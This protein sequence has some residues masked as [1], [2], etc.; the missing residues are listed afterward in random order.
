MKRFI[1]KSVAILLLALFFLNSVVP[2]GFAQTQTAN[3]I[4]V[5]TS[6]LQLTSLSQVYHP[7]IVRGLSIYPNDPF[8]FDFIVDT[9]D[10]KLSG[11]E[12]K[13]ESEKLIKYFLTSLTVPE[14]EL[15]VNLSPYEKDRIIPK[16][17]SATQMGVDMLS[18]D[19]LLKRLTASL[20]YPEKNLGREFWSR[21][22]K[23]AYEKFGTTNVPV[24]TFN[25]VW[26]VPDKAVVYEKNNSVFVAQ[27]HLK[28]ML[29][30]DYLAFSKHDLNQTPTRGHVPL[31]EA[32]GYVSPS[33]L[34]S[35]AGLQLKA[36]QGNNRP[37]NEMT[38]QIVREI[39]LPELEKEV[40]TGKNFAQLRQIY[41]SLILATWYKKKL[42]DTILGQAYIDANK[43]HGINIDDVTTKQKI[44]EQY[45][46]T[47]KKG[48]FNFIKEEYDPASQQ[49]IPRKYFS[50]G[51]TVGSANIKDLVVLKGDAA[52]LSSNMQDFIL[53][54]ESSGQDQKVTWQAVENAPNNDQAQLTILD[55][56]DYQRIPPVAMFP[57]IELPT[58]GIA[59]RKSGEIPLFID[60]SDDLKTLTY[61]QVLN[62]SQVFTNNPDGTIQKVNYDA[63]SEA[64][65][66]LKKIVTF[67]SSYLVSPRKWMIEHFRGTPQGE[68][69]EKIWP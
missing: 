45:I 38:S 34:P 49:T 8:K 20:M 28:V 55:A 21:V 54:P 57:A 29:E 30:E 14:K 65:G 13:K 69:I 24:N 17:L 35:D 44:Y 19:Y 9:G 2:S 18:Q 58:V 64:N 11:T 4:P 33:R 46:K 15:W 66:T 56:H 60:V 48:V 37:T 47:F 1:H 53:H 52:Q 5:D 40:N 32:K 7:A 61:Y 12:F 26:I 67:P 16:A 68:I 42:H 10:Q 41:N 59:H 39:V 63:L 23:Q 51:L 22:Y 27:R 25:K 3:P 31:S 36:P 43:T 62:D 50:G 6:T